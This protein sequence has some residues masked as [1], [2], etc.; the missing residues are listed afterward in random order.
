M[1]DS[2]PK[3]A[4]VVQRYGLE[5]NGGAELECRL[6]AERLTARYDVTIL[7]TCAIDHYTWRDEYAPGEE[8]IH[9]VR[10]VRFRV[11]RERNMETFS[12][13]HGEMMN[14]TH[15][16][17]EEENWLL[18]QG[19]VCPD[20]ITY[21]RTHKA[22]YEAFL[23]M[24]Y[25][26]YP[27]FYGVAEVPEKAI[28]IPTAHDEP[29]IYLSIFADLFRQPKSIF[30]NTL[31][32]QVFVENLFGNRDI[33]SEIGGAGVDLPDTIDSSHFRSDFN[34]EGPYI[35]YVGRIEEGKGCAD[36]FRLIDLYNKYRMKSG[37]EPLT[38]V[39][40][41]KPAMAIPERSY[42]KPLGFVSDNDKYAAITES[43]FLVLPSHFE[44]LS[45]VV[46]E[47]FRLRRPV[48]VNGTCEVLRDHCRI[49][50]AGLY[51][52]TP[53]EFCAFVDYLLEHPQICRQMGENGLHYQ[54]KYYAWDKIIGKLS[55]LIQYTAV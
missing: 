48:L 36:L 28:L 53:E 45:I 19:P 35:V 6:Y 11:A 23:F 1:T 44:S 54:Q 3:I 39:L 8:S 5:V 27:T 13:L 20:L 24:T 21:I 30:Y 12:R 49:S 32:E 9:G 25:L 17:E 7:T 14:G 55:D 51:Y 16:R 41:G 34:I 15:T 26:Y 42:V 40:A 2:K 33:R 37:R 31:S 52:Q 4:M 10:V 29:P 38:L 46:L 18:E 47:A 50:N 22:E 43:E